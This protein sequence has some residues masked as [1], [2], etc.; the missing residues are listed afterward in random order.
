MWLMRRVQETLDGAG[1]SQMPQLGARLKVGES[2]EDY[3]FFES[4]QE[5]A[6]MLG[7]AEALPTDAR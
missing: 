4:L 1:Y 2:L 7:P 6:D 3:H 5:A